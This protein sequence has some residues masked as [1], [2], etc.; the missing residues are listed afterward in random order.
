MLKMMTF[1]FVALN[2]YKISIGK[3]INSNL[4]VDSLDYG[5]N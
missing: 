5:Y 2:D 3:I 1:G 4:R